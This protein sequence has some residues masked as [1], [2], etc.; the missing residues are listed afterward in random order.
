MSFTAD[1]YEII[2]RRCHPRALG[3]TISML[4]NEEEARDMVQQ[5]FV[6]LWET[7]IAGQSGCIHLPGGQKQMPQP[8]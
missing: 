8:P 2:Y 6:S 4:G 5:V 1:E 7:R 3:L